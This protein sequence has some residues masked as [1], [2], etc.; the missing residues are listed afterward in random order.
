MSEALNLSRP[1]AT[2]ILL[3]NSQTAMGNLLKL[4]GNLLKILGKQG[5]IL[6]NYIPQQTF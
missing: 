4:N 2:L 3:T 6:L 1:R 5:H